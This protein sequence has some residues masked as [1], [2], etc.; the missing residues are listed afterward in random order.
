MKTCVKSPVPDPNPIPNYLDIAI[1]GCVCMHMYKHILFR[2]TVLHIR[3]MQT[4][5]QYFKF[6][7]CTHS[8]SLSR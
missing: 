2:R 8:I 1:C 7:V 3:V 6:K 4:Q 5:L